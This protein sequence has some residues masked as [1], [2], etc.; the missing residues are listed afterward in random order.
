LLTDRIK[1]YQTDAEV[2]DYFEVPNPAIADEERRRM[3]FLKRH[4]K[5]MPGF[6]VMDC[7]SGNGW[8]AREFL[9]KG[10]TVVSVDVSAK[11]LK[12]IRQQYDSS[13]TGFYVMADLYD[14]PFRSG[15]FDAATSNDVFEHLEIPETVAGDISRSLKSGGQL[16]VSV[17]YR[18]N[19][20]YYL[21]IHC[22]NPT[23][24]NAHLHSFDETSLSSLFS[25]AGFRI[26]K[27]HRFINK[28]LSI[29]LIYYFLCRW[30]PYWLWRTIDIL[31]NLIIKKQE[32][33]LITM[34][35]T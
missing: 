1:H 29:T 12:Q 3:Q 33:I 19:I 25:G 15:A 32:R 9:P 8:I 2:F 13:N 20:V 31:A 17:P 28:G 24:V 18:E 14:L 7:G 22:N 34:V 6:L 21:C 35:R 10:V 11:N 5:F 30:M 23:P 4:L 16:F 27:N 26:I